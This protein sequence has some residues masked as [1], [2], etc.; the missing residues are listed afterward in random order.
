M[1]K[2]LVTKQDWINLGYQEFALMGISGIVVERMAKKLK[3]NK[4]SFYWYFK[5]KS[6]FID[7]VVEYWIEIETNQIISTT[8]QA[9][10]NEEKWNIFLKITFE[11]SPYLDFIFYLKRYAQ[12]H[13]KI[14]K[15]IDKID[16]E[17]M[18]FTASLFYEF[19]Y[20]KEDAKIKA[21]IFYKYLI[22]YHEMIRNK[23][24]PKNYLTEVI[25]EL[26]H[27]LEFKFKQ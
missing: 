2:L 23:K 12:K 25:S 19:G 11:N 5:T 10:T 21:S 18:N 22:G 15:I 26:N 14:Q 4:S 6:D 8:E 27:F 16:A 24:Q 20:S 9:L 7:A 3:V 1:P 13:E 17:R